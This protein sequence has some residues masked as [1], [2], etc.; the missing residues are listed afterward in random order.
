MDRRDFLLNSL[1][2]TMLPDIHSKNDRGR[3]TKTTV[4]DAHLQIEISC[5][6]EGLEETA[7]RVGGTQLEKLRG[8]PWTVVLNGKRFSPQNHSA[9]LVSAA[10]STPERAQFEGRLA[11]LH[12][13]LTYELTGRGRVTKTLSLTIGAEAI[14]TRVSLWNGLLEQVP[15]IARTKLQDIAAFYRDGERG[16]FASLDF[17]YSHIGVEG[18]SAEISYPPYLPLKPAQTHTCHSLTIGSVQ[19]TGCKRY[20]FDLGE[21]AAMDDYIQQRHRPRFERPMLTTS[22][23]TNRYTQVHG[24]V[25]FYTMKD[26][27]TLTWDRSLLKRDMSVAAKLGMEYYQVFPGVFDWVKGDPSPETVKD[28]VEYADSLGLRIG[29]YSGSNELFCP[30]YNEYQNRLDR[31]NWLMKDAEGKLANGAFCF[32]APDFVEYYINTVVPNCKQF[33]FQIHCLDFLRLYPCYAT[34]HGHPPGPDSLYHQISGLVRLLEA[35]DAVSPEMMTWSNSGVWQELL[36]KLAWSNHNLYLTDPF[37]A[38]PWQGLNMTRLLDDARREQMVKLHYTHFLPYRYYTNCQ[39]FFSQNSV[40]PDIRNFEYGALSSIAVTPNLCLGEIRPWMDQLTALDQGR[41][42][43]FYQ[44]WTD[45]LKEHFELFKKTYH[46]GENPGFGAVEIYAHAEGNR[47]FIFVVNPQ[48]WSRTVEIPL[49]SAL[50]FTGSGKCELREW[51]PT[52]QLRLTATGPFVTLGTKLPMWVPGQQVV[53]L[54]VSP[55]PDQ[56]DTPRLYGLP[57]SVEASEAGFLMKTIG[58]QGYSTRFAVLLP[59]GAGRIAAA[60]ARQDV[61]K[62][63][64]RLWAAT[65]VKLLAAD[66]QASLLELTFRRELAPTELR[67]WE[68]LPG[69]L[70]SGLSA[71]SKFNGEDAR[72]LRFP[73]FVDVGDNDLQLPITD[74][75]ADRMQLGPLASFCGAYFDN[76]FSEDQ[77]TWIDLKTGARGAGG[78]LVATTEKLPPRMALD[79]RARSQ[80]KEWWLRTSFYF[81]FLNGYGAEPAYDEHPRL[82]LPL[83]RQ[84]SVKHLL[85]WI[86]GK[87]LEIQTYSYPRN[88]KLGCYYA[89]LL[90]SGAKGQQS[91]TLVLHL[92]FHPDGQKS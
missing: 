26:N 60:E 86:N 76:A 16:L 2:A 50:G 54:E 33:G 38:T 5:G 87:P 25:V 17:P 46:A 75:G 56:V 20:G 42:I 6:P 13:I 10:A 66:E 24:D 18:G 47:G 14:L 64:K 57:G 69:D 7:F 91:N 92:Q 44:H 58:P 27:P 31:P 59:P 30:H 80:G 82:V 88:R 73:L 63:P 71:S 51:Y 28:F 52:R 61:P 39:Y 12:W 35:I 37:I 67:D 70:G 29:D 19:L 65:D 9:N 8:V 48:Y 45:F 1:G 43:G 81:P 53:V 36:P 3:S 22:C 55:A 49:D 41:V 40:V 68:V 34:G 84:K 90:G 79:P 83:L 11:D 4:G 62:Q 78:G 72:T 89:E 23:I 74:E 15:S 85:G 32:G 77:L 21:V